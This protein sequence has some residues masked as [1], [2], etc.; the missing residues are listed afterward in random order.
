MVRSGQVGP[1]VSGVPVP[2]VPAPLSVTICGHTPCSRYLKNK[3]SFMSTSLEPLHFREDHYLPQGACGP[4]SEGAN[5]EATSAGLV[6]T[7]EAGTSPLT[8]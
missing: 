4:V 6:R 5:Q 7:T 2:P 3:D 8:V 1:P